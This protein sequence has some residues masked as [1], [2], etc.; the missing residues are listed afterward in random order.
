MSTNRSLTEN[1]S[2]GQLAVRGH[3]HEPLELG[4]VHDTLLK[5]AAVIRDEHAKA[6]A[7]QPRAMPILR[8]ELR[9]PLP[10]RFPPLLA[11]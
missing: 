4:P 5:D 10:T 8:R 6:M 3:R 1:A 2:Y 9:M 7:H 11:K